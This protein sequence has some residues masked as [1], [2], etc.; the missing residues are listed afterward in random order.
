MFPFAGEVGGA[1]PRLSGE[2]LQLPGMTE[3]PA[4]FLERG[5][6]AVGSR[7][8][9]NDRERFRPGRRGDLRGFL[10]S[11][12]YK[13]LS[14]CPALAGLLTGPLSAGAVLF[15][16]SAEFGGHSLRLGRLVLVQP[17]RDG[18]GR[19]GAV[20]EHGPPFGRHGR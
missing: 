13:S 9:G 14:T 19:S 18:L 5:G 7:S 4:A 11:G 6:P 2:V 17:V 1:L 10:L 12:G 8:L 20:A 16:L 3:V 15:G